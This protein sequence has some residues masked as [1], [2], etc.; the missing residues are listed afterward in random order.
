MTDFE[1]TAKTVEEAVEEGLKATGL[2]REQAE[3]T[4]LEEGKRKLIGSVKAKVLIRKKKSD[5][6]RAADFLDGVFDILKI[7]ATNELVEEDETI[8]INVIATNT[9]SIIGH[10]GEILD[11]LQ[12]LA[13]AVAN[14]GREEYRRVVVDCENYRER[15]EETLKRLAAKIARKAVERGRKVSLEPMTPYERRVIH[16]ALADSTEVKTQSEGKEPNRYIVVIPNNLRPGSDRF[17]RRGNFRGGHNKGGYQNRERGGYNRDRRSGDREGGRS[18]DRRGGRNERS[19]SP[20]PAKRAPYFGTYLGNSN[21]QK[22]DKNGE[23]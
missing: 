16:S 13:G 15:R 14:I 3:I 8:K 11:S 18:Y 17:E 20:R 12:V 23:E 9:D 21:T 10:R 2:T 4:V 5:G 7:A 22:E 1:F 6:E 19:S